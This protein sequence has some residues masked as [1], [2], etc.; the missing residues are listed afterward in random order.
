MTSTNTPPEEPSPS[1]D[2]EKHE[3]QHQSSTPSPEKTENGVK[4]EPATNEDLKPAPPK[5][6][7]KEPEWLHGFKL[8]TVMAAVTFVCFLMLLDSSIVVTAVP[9]ITNDFHSL[10]DVGW[11]GSAYQLGRYVVQVIDRSMKRD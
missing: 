10:P 3:Q 2:L 9:R 11:Y 1:S 8:F 5:S 4:L 7:G 6:E